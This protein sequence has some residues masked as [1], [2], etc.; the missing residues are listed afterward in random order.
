MKYKDLK[1]K[2]LHKDYCEIKGCSVTDSKVLHHHHIIERTEEGTSD[3]IWNLA[4]LCPNHHTM[5]H[6]GSLRIIGAYPSTATNGRTLVYEIN[7][8]INV[9]GIT[10]MVY[11]KPLNIKGKKSKYDKS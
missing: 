6:T 8:T 11:K 2:K 5:V 10:K 9:D 1:Q 7:N 4:V 3:N